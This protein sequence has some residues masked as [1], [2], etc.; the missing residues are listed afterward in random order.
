MWLDSPAV[1]LHARYDGRS[2]VDLYLRKDMTAKCVETH[3]LGI[4]EN[5]GNYHI[6]GGTIILENI[7]VRYCGSVLID[8]MFFEEDYIRFLIEDNKCGIENTKMTI[9]TNWLN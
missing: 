8:T 1:L 2:V 5:Y 3:M 6:K 9:F 4:N 7:N